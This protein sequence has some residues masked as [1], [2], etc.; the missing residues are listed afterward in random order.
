VAPVSGAE[1]EPKYIFAEIAAII[2]EIIASA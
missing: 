1:D 2:S